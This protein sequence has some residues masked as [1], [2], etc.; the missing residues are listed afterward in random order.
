MTF[1]LT[2]LL[3][4]KASSPAITTTTNH[5]ESSISTLDLES[6]SDDEIVSGSAQSHQVFNLVELTRAMDDA[7]ES[8]HH[9]ISLSFDPM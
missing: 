9:S 4:E 8:H 2:S 5:T 3:Y 7:Y 1:S 6:D